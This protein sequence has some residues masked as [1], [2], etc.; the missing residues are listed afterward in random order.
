MIRGM[1]EILHPRARE[2]ARLLS[3][4]DLPNMD[5]EVSDDRIVIRLQ[6]EKVGS[7]LS[8]I[9]DYLS[10]LKVAMDAMSA[11]HNSSH[12]VR[13]QEVDEDAVSQQ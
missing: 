13:M 9:D 8:I 12:E 5:V 6:A 11:A 10:N 2:I 3:P 7:M 1:V 4:D